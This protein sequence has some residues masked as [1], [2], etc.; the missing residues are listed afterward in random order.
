MTDTT[1]DQAAERYA[2]LRTHIFV[3][4]SEAVDVAHVSA[5]ADRLT[6]LVKPELDA[7]FT[8]R[9]QAHGALARVRAV[10]S[11]IEHQ[12]IEQR[13]AMRAGAMW[14]AHGLLADA[15]AGDD[16]AQ[17]PLD[18]APTPDP[19]PVSAE[20]LASLHRI[21]SREPGADAF[22][23]P[24]MDAARSLFAWTADDAQPPLPAPT[25][26]ADATAGPDVAPVGPAS[27]ELQ[28]EPQRGTGDLA[29]TPPTT[30]T[31]DGITIDLTREYTDS[32]GDTWRWT[33]TW[34]PLMTCKGF[35]PE[36]LRDDLTQ[37]LGEVIRD[38][39]PL[40]AKPDQP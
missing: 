24:A 21:T 25:P 33:G 4:L 23:S 38:Y 15:L 14:E 29:Q 18:A 40:I 11:E 30:W 28:C 2:D 9:E 7:L 13:Y 32:D 20:W 5:T 27:V 3:I 35:D 36:G 19:Q 10:L 16:D 8:D 12:A 1:A 31:H 37:P 6:A 17:P 39:G 34:E 26:H 22:A